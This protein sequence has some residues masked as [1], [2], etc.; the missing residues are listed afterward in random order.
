MAFT[1]LMTRGYPAEADIDTALSNAGLEIP[2]EN[3]ANFITEFKQFYWG[4]LNSL[5]WAM[6]LGV[7]AATATTVNV[8][9]GKYLYK[10]TVKTYTPAAAIDPADNDTT[11]IWL[12]ASNTVSSGTDAAGWPSSEHY[13]LAE[14]TTD[15]DGNITAIT[16]LR[17]QNFL[18]IVRDFIEAADVVCFDGDVVC[19][20]GEIVTY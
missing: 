20:E 19:Y 1:S 2:T 15:S 6:A 16:D 12:T 18:R 3:N 10:G 8:R 14:V 5:S 11:Y 7:Y 17:G 13:K 9:G 4:I